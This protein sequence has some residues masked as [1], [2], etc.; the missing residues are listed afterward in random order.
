M[1]DQTKTTTPRTTPDR[2]ASG[3]APLVIVAAGGT[4]PFEVATAAQAAG[5]NVLV[6]ALEGVADPRL[7]EFR[8][9][10]V[11]WG[12]VGRV[13][14]LIVGHG[15]REVVFIGSVDKRPDFSS[16]G[17]DLGTLKL[18]PLLLRTMVGGDDSVL[19]NIVGFFEERGIRVVGAHEVAPGIV[20]APGHV[21]G[22]RVAAAAL[23]DVRL[24]FQAARAIGE[25]DAGQAAV[26]VNG[27]VIALEA[28]EGTDAMLERVAAL[29]ANGRA[30]WSGRA[31]V[32]VKRSKPQQDL[33]VDMPAIGPR[34]VEGVV[35]A[36]LAGIAVEAGK[37][38]IADR[39]ATIAEAERTRTFIIG[40]DG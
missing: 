2:P 36:N 28:A 5:R 1:P 20:A 18:M 8:N 7:A 6:I 12:Q 25:L 3:G 31:G 13:E 33:R 35:R 24:A 11:K 27:R 19:G 38:M 10:T 4:V 17:V 34:T 22:P 29:H 30:R 21:A 23:N 16:I 15:A 32:L 9:E 39:A 26:A 40:D 14:R 37:V